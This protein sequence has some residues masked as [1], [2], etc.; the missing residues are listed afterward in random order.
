MQR[1]KKHITGNLYALTEDGVW[2][3]NFNSPVAPLDINKLTPI[4]EYPKFLE[5][6]IVNERNDLSSFDPGSLRFDRA[7][8]ISDGYDFAEKHKLLSNLPNTVA[9][10]ATNRSLVKWNTNR[11]IDFFL[12]NNPYEECMSLLPSHRY[13]PRCLASTR[14]YP[15]FIETYKSRG[16]NVLTYSVSPEPGYSS[17]SRNYC[18]LDDYRNP[19]CAAISLAH[20][21]GVT[22]LM[23]VCCDD[24][25]DDERPAAVKL[26]N[27]LWTYPQH[28]MCH[29]I[30]G[31]MLS[32]YKKI[33]GTKI[34]DHSSGPVYKDAPY[35]P[36]EEMLKFFE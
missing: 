16:G 36:Q 32:W 19:V 9:V 10:I 15:Q 24:S 4:S 2:V 3:R 30:I 23:L 28:L 13:Y 25:F 5:N 6:E 14:T 31:T 21:V 27:G 33:K 29:N 12:A 8:I 1:I 7:V 35:I 11:K 18:Q 22:K 34:G 26:E 20:K 17:P